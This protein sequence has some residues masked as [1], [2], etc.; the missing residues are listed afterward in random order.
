MIQILEY[1]P[2][3]K[4]KGDFVNKFSLR[5]PAEAIEDKT[6]SITRKYE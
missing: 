4:C 6:S 1:W 2:L 5:G 3:G